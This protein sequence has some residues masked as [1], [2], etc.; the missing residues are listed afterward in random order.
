MNRALSADMRRLQKALTE[1]PT[2]TRAKG[3]TTR[4]KGRSKTSRKGTSPKGRTTRGKGQNDPREGHH[5]TALGGE[6]PGIGQYH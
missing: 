1:K 6:A 2:P 3:T 4:G 5:R